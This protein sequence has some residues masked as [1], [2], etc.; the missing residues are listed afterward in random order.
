M[1]KIKVKF[2]CGD[3]CEYF[4]YPED[5]SELELMREFDS[6]FEEI[7]VDAGWQ[8]EGP[9]DEDEDFDYGEDEILDYLYIDSKP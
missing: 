5:I 1:R 9:V 7:E 3:E 2:Y 6:W 4:T 8:I